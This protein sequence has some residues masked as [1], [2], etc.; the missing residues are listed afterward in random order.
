MAT[1]GFNNWTEFLMSELD[2]D[3]SPSF[4]AAEK[5]LA[6]YKGFDSLGMSDMKLVEACRSR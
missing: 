4:R 5:D 3:G 1:R 2:R 6:F